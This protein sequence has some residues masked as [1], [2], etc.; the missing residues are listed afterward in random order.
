MS[1]SDGDSATATSAEARAQAIIESMRE[2]EFTRLVEKAERVDAPDPTR[3]LAH[4]ERYRQE[5]PAPHPI[6]LD[7]EAALIRTALDEPRADPTW[8]LRRTLTIRALREFATRLLV[9]RRRGELAT[10]DDS[11]ARAISD[12]AV[13][14]SLQQDDEP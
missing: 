3:F 7:A 13:A 10:G 2:R 5:D 11:Y 6:A 14:L 8:S 9:A 4:L 1:S 12:L